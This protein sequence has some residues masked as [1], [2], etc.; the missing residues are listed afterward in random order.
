MFK[1]NSS[2]QVALY[3]QHLLR[4]TPIP[5]CVAVNSSNS[6]IIKDCPN[7]SYFRGHHF[8][9]NEAQEKL[10]ASDVAEIKAVPMFRWEFGN[11]ILNLTST[12][13]ANQDYYSA[14][15]HER[16]G[17]YLR[18]YRDYYG[19]DLMN[20]YNCF[21]NRLYSNL[22]LPLT[23]RDG[24][25]TTSYSQSSAVWWQSS[26]VSAAKITCFPIRVGATYHIKIYSKVKG[27]VLLQPMF[28]VDGRPC[29]VD[30]SSTAVEGGPTESFYLLTQSVS[31]R[32]FQSDF[33]FEASPEN[34]LSNEALS[35][36]GTKLVAAKRQLL[37]KQKYLNLLIQV[38]GEDDLQISVVEQTG[39]PTALNNS[40]LQLKNVGYNVPFSDRLLEYLTGN[41]ITPVDPISRNIEQVQRIV[42][43][44]DFEAAYG[45]RYGG[46][47]VKGRY[48]E[49]LRRFIYNTFSDCIR[50]SEVR[51]DSSNINTLVGTKIQD[52]LGYVDKDVEKLLWG[53]LSADSRKIIMEG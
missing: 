1:Y 46:N 17:D 22:G 41:V 3:I 21:S 39:Y 9:R 47:Y 49:E 2:S 42:S 28:C 37:L 50:S 51:V 11:A 24:Q 26:P 12:Y 15:V 48:D 8:W 16:L 10:E 29:R 5:Q 33:Y 43:S 14:E 30:F 4:T 25:E 19:V 6:D 45:V 40:L 23:V 53:C 32:E 34:L 20:F 27:A 18:V 13:A 52:F 35:S 44:D 38:P 7:I 36:S 31:K